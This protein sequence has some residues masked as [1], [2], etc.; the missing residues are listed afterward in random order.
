[1]KKIGKD[2]TQTHRH[3]LCCNYVYVYWGTYL[4]RYIKTSYLSSPS[5]DFFLFIW[6][7]IAQADWLTDWLLDQHHQHQQDP[8][9][10]LHSL[11]G[12]ACGWRHSSTPHHKHDIINTRRLR[13]GSQGT[14]KTLSLYCSIFTHRA[15]EESEWEQWFTASLVDV[16]YVWCDIDLGLEGGRE[17]DV[18]LEWKSTK[19]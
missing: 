6:R 17:V 13:T 9:H 14:K 5:L 4:L 11:D 1:M 2:N 15:K 19:M 10:V 12:V 8:L 18:W 7:G 3:T 16:I